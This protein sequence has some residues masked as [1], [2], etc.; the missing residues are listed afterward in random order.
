VSPIISLWAI[1]N[2][3]QSSNDKLYE[4]WNYIVQSVDSLHKD[5][6][7]EAVEQSIHESNESSG[8]DIGQYEN[9]GRDLGRQMYYY[10][11]S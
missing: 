10:L 4:Q 2:E 1:S 8:T 5:T 3:K 11:E 9:Y 7:G 6:I